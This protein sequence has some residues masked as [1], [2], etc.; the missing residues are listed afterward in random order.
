[1]FTIISI[2]NEIVLE[3]T[4]TGV[5]RESVSASRQ[6]KQGRA[7]QNIVSHTKIHS[8]HFNNPRAEQEGNKVSVF[9]WILL[10]SE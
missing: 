6:T 2:I 10:G 7:F 8:A 3:G 9:I 4:A 5:G 1:M